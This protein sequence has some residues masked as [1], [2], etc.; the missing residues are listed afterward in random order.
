MLPE[1][2]PLKENLV[3]SLGAC[4]A[5]GHQLLIANVSRA[6]AA[7][8]PVT[9]PV[10]LPPWQHPQR[11]KGSWPC[12]M[13]RCR[14]YLE[15]TSS[16][17]ST[18]IS[19]QRS[20]LGH[21]GRTNPGRWHSGCAWLRGWDMHRA[22]QDSAPPGPHSLSPGSAH[23]KTS[24]SQKPRV[25]DVMAE[26]VFTGNLPPSSSSFPIPALHCFPRPCPLLIFMSPTWVTI[27]FTI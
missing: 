25:A 13:L 11:D 9:L 5:Q 24:P 17:S 12:C 27:I 10:T 18:L 3:P 26:L 4:S 16:L 21:A 2:C 20:Y 23:G 19:H 22:R 7:G 14:R 15:N 1:S 6:R 8:L